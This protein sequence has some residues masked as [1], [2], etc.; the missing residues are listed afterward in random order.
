M[1]NFYGIE[2][3]LE[4]I[5]DLVGTFFRTIFIF[6]DILQY[7]VKKVTLYTKCSTKPPGSSLQKQVLANGDARMLLIS[8]ILMC[9]SSL[10]H[11]RSSRSNTFTSQCTHCTY[12][13][14]IMPAS[15]NNARVARGV[16]RAFASR[17]EHSLRA[18]RTNQVNVL[19]TIYKFHTFRQ[20]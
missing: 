3:P 16:T 19:T 6:P 9:W 10:Y 13:L 11:A 1:A 18:W 7:Q 12:A 8:R 5:K 20:A 2:L 17:P 15:K 4:T 14:A